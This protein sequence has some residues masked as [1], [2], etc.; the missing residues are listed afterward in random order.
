MG[1]GWGEDEVQKHEGLA[2]ITNCVGVWP[3]GW[4][5]WGGL[6]GSGPRL[7]CGLHFWSALVL[8]SNTFGWFR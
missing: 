5:R 1:R 7:G 2:E 6:G 3:T 4:G 8:G